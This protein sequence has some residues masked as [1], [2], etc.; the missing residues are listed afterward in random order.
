MRLAIFSDVHGNLS[1]LEAVLADIDRQGADHIVFAG[2]LC[3]MGPRPAACLR[4][5]RER[6]ITAV[7]G[8]TDEWLTGRRPPPPVMAEIAPWTRGELSKNDLAWLDA[9]PIALRFQMTPDPA[10]ALLV[11]HANPVDVNQII[12]PSEAKQ[13]E[14]YG[15]VRQPDAAL[16]PL[17]TGQTLAAVAFGHLHVPNDR[18]W[19]AIDLINISS[20][21]MPGDS[22][23]RAKYALIEWDES[24]WTWTRH[25]VEYNGKAEVEAFRERRPPGW[26][27]FVSEL[28]ANGYYYPQKV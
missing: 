28:E 19:G 4:L 3:L 1:A 2:D 16:G 23:G 11:T 15:E 25:Y 18:R 24:R 13:V 12:Y 27:A 10:G 14:R 7:Y 17:L 6:H 20:V 8:N 5:V 22:D 21:S 26:E 9:L